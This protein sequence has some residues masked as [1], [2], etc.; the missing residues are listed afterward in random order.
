MP[1]YLLT[2]LPIFLW[3]VGEIVAMISCG[4][5]NK[6]SSHSDWRGGEGRG[7]EGRKVRKVRTVV[8][9]HV[10]AFSTVGTV[11]LNPCR[12]PKSLPIL[13]SSIFAKKNGFPVVKALTKNQSSF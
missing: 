7:R 13:N 4:I 1:T 3:P 11:N 8:N 10:W 6:H 12:A 2:P 5:T 9:G